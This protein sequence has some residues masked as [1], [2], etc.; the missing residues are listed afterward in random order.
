MD[1]QAESPELWTFLESL[2]SGEILTGT[3]AAIERFGVFVALDEGPWHPVFPGVGFLTVPELSWRRLDRPEDVVRVGQRVTCEF[4]GFDTHNAE[5]R[6]SLCA[7]QPDP[8]RAFAYRTEAGHVLRGTVT[9]VCPIG[10]FVDVGDGIEGLA[11]F[12]EHLGVTEVPGVRPAAGPEDFEVGDD[13]VIV[14]LHIDLSRRRLLFALLDDTWQTS[15]AA[16][17]R[18]TGRG[19]WTSGRR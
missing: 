17:D 18:Q 11:P 7:L 3:V 9:K 19:A 5:A 1:W 10:V 6:L 12:S 4:L 16:P 13:V 2:H 8:L 15:V 14:V